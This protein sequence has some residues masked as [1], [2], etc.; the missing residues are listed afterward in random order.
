MRRLWAYLQRYR[1]RYLAGGVC[2]LATATL[3][4]VVPYLL[5]EAIDGIA[6]G[7]APGRVASYALWIVGIALV[8]AVVRSF[9]RA[10]IFNVGRDVEYDLRND[11]F[12]HLQKLP[13]SYYHA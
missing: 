4:M 11:L 3:A 8:Q 9:S 7:V 1:W 5:K 10:L 12:A 6:R 13:L 2:L